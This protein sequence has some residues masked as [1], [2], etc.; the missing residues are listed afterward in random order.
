M[1]LRISLSVRIQNDAINLF[2][3]N[4]NAIYLNELEEAD[5]FI[6]VLCQLNNCLQHRSKVTVPIGAKQLIIIKINGD[7]Q[8]ITHFYTWNQKF[9][10]LTCL[11]IF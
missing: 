7:R 5:S 1:Y 2:C 4:V 11:G 8:S 9:I 3:L 10:V 6:L